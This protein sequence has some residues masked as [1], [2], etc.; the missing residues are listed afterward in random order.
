MALGLHTL[1]ADSIVDTHGPAC[2]LCD[3]PSQG[4]R[5][6][7]Q[8]KLTEGILWERAASAES[9]IAPPPNK[10][11]GLQHNYH[12]SAIKRQ[13]PFLYSLISSPTFWKNVTW[14]L[15]TTRC[16]HLWSL[17]RLWFA[18]TEELRENESYL[19]TLLLQVVWSPGRSKGILQ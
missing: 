6:K 3:W 1:C 8:R 7:Y 2:S 12:F 10:V 5:S 16:G 9:W 15:R 11:S 14:S 4:K 13:R 18:C 19:L 17:P